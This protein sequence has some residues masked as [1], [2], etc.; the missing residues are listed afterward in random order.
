MSLNVRLTATKELRR[1]AA[2]ALLRIA[3]QFQ[4][5]EKA[6][7]LHGPPRSKE[8]EHL[9]MDT[10]NARDN[11]AYSPTSIDAVAT[12]LE[13][14]VGYRLNAWYASAWE[15]KG[16]RIGLFEK[17]KQFQQARIPANIMGS[18]ER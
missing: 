16:K 2:K 1:Q 4:T 8:G 11:L 7:W 13:V 5:A 3:V 17:L 12:D 15:L 9:K 14:R 10:M 18:Y 6:E